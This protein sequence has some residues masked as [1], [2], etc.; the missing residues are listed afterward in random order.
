MIEHP[1]ND[2]ED[3]EAHRKSEHSSYGLGPTVYPP[4]QTCERHGL[5]NC[6]DC[7]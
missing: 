2:E 5:V 4:G 6:K 3:A 1:E 7:R